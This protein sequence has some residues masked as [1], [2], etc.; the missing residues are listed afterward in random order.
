MDFNTKLFGLSVVVECTLTAG[1]KQTYWQPS[2]EDECEIEN[3]QHK[4]CDIEIDSL[5]DA[6]LDAIMVEAFAVATE[7]ANEE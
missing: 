6:E 2:S 3:I 5:P 7:R 4:G 1:D